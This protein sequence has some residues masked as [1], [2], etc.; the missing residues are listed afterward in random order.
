MAAPGKSLLDHEPVKRA[1]SDPAT[2]IW[3][4]DL[5]TS[6]VARDP[7]DVLADLEHAS[8]LVRSYFKALTDGASYDIRAPK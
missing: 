7:V 1:F 3:L 6:A 2:R 5:L 4:C 8:A